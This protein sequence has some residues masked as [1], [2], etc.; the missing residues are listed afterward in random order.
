M[1]AI[2]ALYKTWPRGPV[3]LDGL[4]LEVAAGEVLALLGPSGCGK[5]TLLRVLAGLEVPDAGSVSL[6]G[7]PVIEGGRA[8][9]PPERRGVGLVFQDFALFPHLDVRHNV[10]FG[11]RHLDP[12]AREARVDALLARFD[13]A[14]LG[15]RRPDELSGGQ[16]QRVAL[17]RALAPEPRI[18]LLDEP[19]SN[20]DASLRRRLRVA[21]REQ[22]KAIGVTTV[23]VTH[24]ESEA[25]SLADRV[26]VLDAGRVAQ[27]A[28]PEVI[29]G[30]P[31]SV[32]VAR[33]TGQVNAVPGEALGAWIRTP[34][35]ELRGSGPDG[36][37]FALLRPEQLIL[38]AESAREGARAR[39]SARD[40]T[41]AEL[42]LWLS[43]E[44]LPEPLVAKAAGSNAG[45]GEVH[46]GDTVRVQVRGA[47]SWCA[48]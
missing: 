10:A 16:Q 11:L 30:K 5:T 41:G 44:G 39:V 19:F 43:V 15:G 3:V 45:G 36:D 12:R 46:V 42:E 1:I 22:L 13:L 38:G 8:L 21:L 32:A 23:L 26:A 37:A 29:Y 18:L 17:A 7:R 35:G 31:A 48:R 33:A 9:V 27:V 24:D 40:Y 34:L 28:P 14:S 6:D 47:V 4:S 2:D 20:L 25:L